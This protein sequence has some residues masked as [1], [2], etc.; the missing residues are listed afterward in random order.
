MI[1]IK[2]PIELKSRRDF[3]KDGSSFT[4]R[5]MGN[6]S[7]LGL[8][9][10]AEELLHMMSSPPEIYIAQEGAQTVVGNTFITRSNEDRLEVVNNMLNRIMLSVNAPLTY[11]DRAYITDALYKIGIKDDKTFMSEV[12]RMMNESALQQD[13]INDYL[14]LRY[15]SENTQLREETLNLSRQVAASY[16]E[17]RI[18]QQDNYLA[19]II[20]KRLETGAIYQIV[21]NFSK[22]VSDVRID[23]AEQMVSEQE[24]AARNMLISTFLQT[25]EREGAEIIYRQDVTPFTEED[26]TPEAVRERI[27]ENESTLRSETTQS[28]LPGEIRTRQ[29]IKGETE[30][31]EGGHETAEMV[32]AGPVKEG[33]ARSAEEGGQI[34]ASSSYT[35]Q[36]INHYERRLLSGDVN[37][38]DI[39]ENISAAVF[40]DIV[41]NLYHAG[42]EKITGGDSWIEY[43]GSLYNAQVNTINR[44]S[45][46]DATENYP[47]YITNAA[48]FS[49]NRISLD[50]AE[51]EEL[52]AIEENAGN[53][54]L[55]ENQIRSM[56][57]SNLENVNRYEQMIEMLKSLKPERRE[58][59]GAMMT[60][61]ESLAALDDAEAVL[62]RISE[63]E[64][65]KEEEKRGVFREITRLFP[66]NAAQ[67]FNVVEQYLSNPASLEGLNVSVNNVSQAAEEIMRL[68][69]ANT[70][71]TAAE[72]AVEEIPSGGELFHKREERLTSEELDEIL[73][74]YSRGENRSVRDINEVSDITDMR[75]VNTTTITHN[76]ERTLSRNELEDIEEMVNRG[77]R[78]QMGAIS[79]QVLTKLEKR[80][81][82]EKSRRGI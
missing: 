51:F 20:M 37:S 66:D 19:G 14:S 5:I 31:T 52:S 69:A 72:R 65:A 29:E 33:A 8:D 3:I 48:D 80:L 79:E 36:S 28:I 21:A 81:R 61:K 32:Y 82:N 77:V 67:V 16:T 50:Y 57:E 34:P 2:A 54:E 30:E 45:R 1:K 71:H 75:T 39:T 17:E 24:D 70:E 63:G 73:E 59:G 76:T 62:K 47:S 35:Y 18:R 41:R 12:R 68:Q 13:F 11:Q 4:E 9:I 40:L 43:R 6:Y 58:G 60:R 15:D 10:G 23:N 26:G 56:N 22:S 27:R 7:I 64:D 25:M 55:I 78:S 53:I 49:E 74:N 42:Y 44:M 38:E 46:V